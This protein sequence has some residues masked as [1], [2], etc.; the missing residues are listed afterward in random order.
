MFDHLTQKLQSVFRRLASKGVLSEADV[1]SALHE[2][3]LALLEA[4]VHFQVVV[5]FIARAGER[6]VGAEVLRS[7]TPAQQVVKIVQ[8]ELIHLLGEPGRL[9]LAGPGPQGVMLVGL[10]GSGKTTTAAKLALYLRQQGQRPLLVATDTR[11]PAAIQQLEVLGGQIGIAVH[12]EGSDRAPVEIARHAVERARQGSYTAVIL[13]T[14]GRLHIDAELM[15]ELAEMKAVLGTPQVLLVAD[16]MTGQ[17]AVNLAQEFQRR[18]GLSG[19]I[20]TKMDGDARGGAAL[21]IRQVSGVPI[22]FLGTGEK[23][24][25]LEVFHPERLASRI[26]GMGD[27]L[28]LIEKAE[29][30]FDQEEA[31]RAAEKIAQ[32]SFDLEDFLA[33]LQQVK[34]MGPLS[35]LVEM[36]P[37]LSSLAGQLP[38]GASDAQLSRVEAMLRSMTPQER[39]QPDI[40]GGSRKRRIARGSGTSVQEVNQLLAQ[41]KQ[42]QKMMKQ[43]QAGRLGDIPSMF[44]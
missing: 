41:F 7:L 44:R 30:A 29:E 38:A 32:A 36:V 8:E 16:A 4:D 34:R 31:R 15:G 35:Q 14:Q 1:E 17:D 21:S 42:V 22:L 33:Q 26:L 3:R 19:L 25:A 9:N 37:G 27:V 12:S 20:L 13:D 43:L 18:V 23:P 10:Q 2:V 24:S 11:R 6:A 5:D 28:S 40:I 39:R